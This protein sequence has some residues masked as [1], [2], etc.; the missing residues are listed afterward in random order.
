MQ[1]RQ[2]EEEDDEDNDSQGDN[3]PHVS[4]ST[5]LESMEPEQA[6]AIKAQMNNMSEE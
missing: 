2:E 3:Y 5:I 1:M 4:F 6:M